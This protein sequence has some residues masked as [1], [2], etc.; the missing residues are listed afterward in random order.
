VTG[1]SQEPESEP[2]DLDTLAQRFQSDIESW[3]ASEPAKDSTELVELVS[4]S[5]TAELRVSSDTVEEH[6][7]EE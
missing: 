2:I 4:D 3:R 1:G 5:T 7:H 6:Q